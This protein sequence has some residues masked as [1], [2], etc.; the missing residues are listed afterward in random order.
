MIRSHACGVSSTNGAKPTMPALVTRMCTG[1]SSLRTLANASS[2]AA[3]SLTSA[4]TA[5]RR[6]AV[7]P[8]FFG[9]PLR[10]FAVDV[11][12]GDLVA[13]PAQFVTRRL[14]HAG[15]AAGHHRYPTHRLPIE[16][17]RYS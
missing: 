14:T 15:C 5:E 12:H 4:A 8:Q 9:D 7:G 3:R 17:S 1:P 11:E 2:T 10:R 6:D 13:A 16:V